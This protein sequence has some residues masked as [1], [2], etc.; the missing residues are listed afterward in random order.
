MK[1]AWVHLYS[2]LFLRI[3]MLI[4]PQRILHYLF[5]GPWWGFYLSPGIAAGIDQPGCYEQEKEE[6]GDCD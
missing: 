6:A 2:Q 5:W 3:F 4:N 1:K